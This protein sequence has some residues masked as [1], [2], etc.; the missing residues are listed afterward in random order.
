MRPQWQG[1]II[2]YLPIVRFLAHCIKVAEVGLLCGQVK[3]H[4]PWQ[5]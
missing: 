5:L 3:S 4:V 1:Q 2:P